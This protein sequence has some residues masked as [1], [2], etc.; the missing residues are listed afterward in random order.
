MIVVDAGAIGAAIT[1]FIN[2]NHDIED[3]SNFVFDIVRDYR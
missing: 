3:F 2:G 1:F